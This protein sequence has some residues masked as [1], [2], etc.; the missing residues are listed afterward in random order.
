M[1]NKR[2]S[3]QGHLTKQGTPEQLTRIKNILDIVKTYKKSKI[4][5]RHLEWF[6]EHNHLEFE[7]Y[8]KENLLERLIFKL[9]EL[10]PEL[11]DTRYYKYDF[12]ENQLNIVI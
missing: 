6:A 4:T 3:I 12:K 1:Q 9:M 10:D 8:I 2:V 7:F 11:I 5:K